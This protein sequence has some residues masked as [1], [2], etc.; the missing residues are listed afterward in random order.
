[1]AS[2]FFGPYRILEKVGKEASMLQLTIRSKIHPAIHVSRLK[3]HASSVATQSQL[4]IVGEDGTMM[5]E[6]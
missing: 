4:P 3:K 1:M 5:R 6:P 2:K